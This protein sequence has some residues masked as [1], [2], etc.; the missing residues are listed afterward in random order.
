MYVT[1]AADADA[2]AAAATA[3]S[4]TVE[5]TLTTH[6]VNAQWSN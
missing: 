1:T 6:Q 5:E 2:A 3:T 4:S